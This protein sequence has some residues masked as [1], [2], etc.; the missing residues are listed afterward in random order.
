MAIRKLDTKGRWNLYMDTETERSF[1]RI[2]GAIA[3]PADGPGFVVVVGEEAKAHPAPPY[4]LHVLAEA[5]DS[6]PSRLILKAQELAQVFMVR[7]FYG[8]T[9]NR[10]DIEFL[11]W[12]NR[13]A[14]DRREST[15][16]IREAPATETDGIHF[17]LN[18][19]LSRLNAAEKTLHMLP[20]SKLPGHL[21]ELQGDRLTRA[22]ASEHPAIAALGY[23]VSKL[24]VHEYKFQEN[25]I[26]QGGD[27][28][29]FDHI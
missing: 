3:W 21:L 27:Y 13:K 28:N 1:W 12:Y 4:H 16:N 11:T 26:A 7:D 8:Y 24:T 23:V 5:D 18:I 15:L 29:P 9:G 6:N 10:A 14:R 17:H 20:E 19:L 22:T 2:L 25:Q